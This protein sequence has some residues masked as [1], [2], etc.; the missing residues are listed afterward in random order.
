M[1][2][3]YTDR[4]Y[5]LA[6]DHRASFSSGLFGIPGE[7]LPDQLAGIMISKQIIF[8]GLQRALPHLKKV[9]R[10]VPGLLVDEQ[11]GSEVAR[12]AR[13][14]GL[15]LAMPV[16]KSGQEEFDFD[17]GEGYQTHVE[18]FNPTFSKVLVR[19]NPDGDRD[20]NRRQ[21]A[22]L[23]QLSNWLHGQDR[24]FLFELLVP[25][26]RAQL[27][28]VDGS[29][30]RYDLELRPDLV[31][32]TIQECQVGEVE[33]DIWKIEGLERSE[34]CA[35][36]AGAARAGGRDE[37]CCVVLGRGADEQKVV[38]WLRE[39]AKVP[40]FQGFA[41]GRTIWWDALKAWVAGDLDRS[42]AAERVSANYR[43]MVAAYQ[44]AAGG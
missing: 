35:R 16:E 36:V 24:K 41:V 37:V 26:T 29:S 30:D 13:I 7:P 33:P 34:D 25:A 31:V 15:T 9:P 12:R 11:Y 43:R 1:T 10:H 18:Q 42:A 14:E 2:L 28:Q 32:R 40:G 17:Y 6:F 38:H 22:R 4:L 21:L 3:G 27:A 23:A 20:L 5:L 39:G 8:E 44:S 19:Y